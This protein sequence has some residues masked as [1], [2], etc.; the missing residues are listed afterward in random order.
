MDK[1][2]AENLC[3]T[4]ASN[5]PSCVWASY[6]MVGPTD[7]FGKM[8]AQNLGDA[9]FHIP[10]FRDF[11]TLAAQEARFCA[12]AAWRAAASCT[13]ARAHDLVL[14]KE[15]RAVADK[16]E[17]LDELEEWEL[18]MTHYCITI[19]TNDPA[20]SKLVELF[21]SPKKSTTSAV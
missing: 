8:M 17:R 4:L 10:G 15:E 2:F 3:A 6:D 13:M 14:S 20:Y 7:S 12:A 19:T 18:L 16:I 11:P 9:G 21:P 1:S 5:L